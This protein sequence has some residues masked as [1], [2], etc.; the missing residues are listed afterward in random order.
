MAQA[1]KRKPSWK[2]LVTA[3]GGE[4][5]EQGDGQSPPAVEQTASNEGGH[6]QR[7][8]KRTPSPPSPS[9]P[10]SPPAKA[11]KPGCN[12]AVASCLSYINAGSISTRRQTWSNPSPITKDGY[13]SA[14]LTTWTGV[15]FQLQPNVLDSMQDSDVTLG[16]TWCYTSRG[17]HAC[18]YCA[19]MDGP[20]SAGVGCHP[21]CCLIYSNRHRR[22]QN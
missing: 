20:S 11:L 5:H 17:W 3:T 13:D 22:Q 10:P 18:Q 8:S 19:R 16:P 14:A 15:P 2:S 21:R 12:R 9:S 1:R 7:A 6:M 4:V